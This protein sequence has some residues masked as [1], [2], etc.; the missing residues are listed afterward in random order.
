MLR[1]HRLLS[2]FTAGGRRDHGR[3]EAESATVAVLGAEE[4]DELA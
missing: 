1:S 2:C 4:A 3:V